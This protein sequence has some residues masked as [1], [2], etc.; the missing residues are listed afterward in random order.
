[1]PPV[2]VPLE[3]WASAKAERT[4]HGFNQITSGLRKLHVRPEL[5]EHSPK[6][7]YQKA[8][9]PMPHFRP[10]LR[11]PLHISNLP[12]CSFTS[13]SA[14]EILS[15]WTL[16]W[17]VLQGEPTNLPAGWAM[18]GDSILLSQIVDPPTQKAGVIFCSLLEHHQTN[19]VSFFG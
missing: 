9:D 17:L 14:W 7:H 4:C 13:Q 6:G 3:K 18:S 2:R 15:K 1:M 8:T 12:A 5:C 19:T 10:C 11:Q 16:F